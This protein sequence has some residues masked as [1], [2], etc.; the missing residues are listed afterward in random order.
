MFFK[1]PVVAYASTF[2]VVC[3]AGSVAQIP[4]DGRAGAATPGGSYVRRED[5]AVRFY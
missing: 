5:F 2:I 1:T 4:G 3:R